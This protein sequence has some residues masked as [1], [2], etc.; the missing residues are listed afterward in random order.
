MASWANCKLPGY[1]TGNPRI[2]M[3]PENGWLECD[4]FLLESFG[5]A[6]SSGA[7]LLVVS[8]RVSLSFVTSITVQSKNY[9]VTTPEIP[10]MTNP[11]IHHE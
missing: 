9:A 10:N 1:L 11:Q 7:K 5:M 8:G 6:F 2:D 4:C 3:A